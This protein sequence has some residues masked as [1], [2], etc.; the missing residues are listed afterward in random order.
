MKNKTIILICGLMLVAC[1]RA[2]FEPVN[3]QCTIEN[4]TIYCPDGSSAQLPEDGVDGAPGIDGRDGVDGIDGKDGTMVDV[5]DPC[6]DDPGQVDE[7][8]LLFDGEVHLAWYKNVGFVVLEENV[9]YR[10]TD[11]Q[12]CEFTI[13]N[14]EVVSL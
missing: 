12:K 13:F 1:E 3:Y 10:T 11:K 6:G 14:G 9:R 5:V 4:N 2:R 8:I 7:V